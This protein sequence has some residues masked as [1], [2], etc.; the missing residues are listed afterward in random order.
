MRNILTVIDQILA[1]LPNPVPPEFSDNI[2]SLQAELRVIRRSA[3]YMPP[4]AVVSLWPRVGAV[5]YRYLPPP[6]AASWA[7][8]IAVIVQG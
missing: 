3:E 4:E 7:H 1:A 6:T 5:L 8:A 2:Q